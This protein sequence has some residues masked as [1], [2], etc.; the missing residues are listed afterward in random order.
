MIRLLAV[1][2]IAIPLFGCP[3]HHGAQ[4]TGS[5]DGEVADSLFI[6]AE[7]LTGTDMALAE[8]Y[9]SQARKLLE[10][11]PANKAI[12][13]Y[14]MIKGR[15]YYYGNHY[16]CSLTHVDSALVYLRCHLQGR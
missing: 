6:M 7:R 1:A 8:L 5:G 9:L 11:N 3:S 16:T 10:E 13:R 14:H 15:I 12:G 4:E 2:F